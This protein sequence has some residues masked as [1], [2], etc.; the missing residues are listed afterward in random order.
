[1][2]HEI[3]YG[4]SY[5][6]LQVQLEAGENVVA[7]P[8]AMVS[9][10]GGVDVETKARGGLFGGLKRTFLGGESFF[11]NT[12]RASQRGEVTFAPP[13]AGDVM[14]LRLEGQPVLAQSGAFLAG[15][16]TIEI[17]SKWGGARGFFSGAG[18][19]LLKLAGSGDLWISA[20]GAI[21]SRTLGPGE[22]YVV[23]TGHIVAFDASVDYS[24]RRVGGIKSTLFSGEGLVADFTGPGRV[25]LQTRSPEAFLGW[26][27]GHMPNK[28]QQAAAFGGGGLLAGS[29]F[30]GGG[31]GDGGSD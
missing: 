14:H 25:W 22:R 18:L 31:D 16:P 13:V 3:L 7:E 4:P 26:L 8:G 27:G 23:D 11:L 19:I 10:A 15:S 2:R 29:L 30:G 24:V 9:L 1:L 20:Y 28:T 6:L 5:S 12:F 21:H 17:D